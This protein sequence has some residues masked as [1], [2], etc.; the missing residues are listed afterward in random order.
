MNAEGKDRPEPGSIG[1]G[2]P[3]R[4]LDLVLKSGAAF[5]GQLAGDVFD[6][7]VVHLTFLVDGVVDSREDALRFAIAL[8]LIAKQAVE[9]AN[10]LPPAGGVH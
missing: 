1:E 7:L 8:Q 9:R 6:A 2:L 3:P 5:D 10:N 4:V